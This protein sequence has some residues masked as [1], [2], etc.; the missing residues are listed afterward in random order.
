MVKLDFVTGYGSM[1]QQM[2]VERAN[3]AENGILRVMTS[4]GVLV[5]SH[6]CKQGPQHLTFALEL[7]T[8]TKEQIDKAMTMA[9]PI[10]GAIRDSP[11]NL[12]YS[13][14]FVY[15]QIPSPVQVPVYA[16]RLQG[17]GCAVPIGMTTL[18]NVRGVDF[19]NPATA[20]LVIVAGTGRGKTT[21]A[22]SI[23]YGLARQNKPSDLRL[24][25]CTFK[26]KDWSAFAG[27]P[28][29]A[30]LATDPGEIVRIMRWAKAEVYKRS[31]SG[32]DHPR[33]VVVLDDM[34]NWG[35]VADVSTEVSE[36]GSLGRA[37]GIHLLIITQKL[38][39]EGTGG[40]N[41]Q[42]IANI[43]TRLVL[44]ATSA[45]EAAQL[46]G[47][48]KSGAETLGRYMGDA[49]LVTNGT[50]VRLACAIVDNTQVEAL[51]KGV[52]YRDDGPQPWAGGVTGDGDGNDTLGGGLDNRRDV[53]PSGAVQPRQLVHRIGHVPVAGPGLRKPGSLGTVPSE[54]SADAYG[55][56][57]SD[58][59]PEIEH[60]APGLS[61]PLERIDPPTPAQVEVIA[62]V[63]RNTRS[64]NKTIDTCYGG[65]GKKTH[66]L[67]TAALLAAGIGIPDES[68]G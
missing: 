57:E 19:A 7:L 68:E 5:A 10:E 61:L 16:H 39:A 35:K 62:T 54:P 46:T 40:K 60:D 56:P 48:P 41:S 58:D 17:S 6:G 32:V 37:S 3:E 9:L 45:Q 15:V 59:E 64:I 25:V 18:R 50:P 47:I 52:T 53:L 65:K 44:G 28:H 26:P 63:Y 36:I 21:A 22:R 8:N 66:R 12:R 11:V 24:V 67:V 38:T 51:S 30:P 14:G 42:A 29:M 2:V 13:R 49:L 20:H 43:G 31:K 33:Y 1:A 34:Y 4:H 55:E 23:L 27:L